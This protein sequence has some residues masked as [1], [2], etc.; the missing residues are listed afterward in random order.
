MVAVCA[1]VSGLADAVPQ[2]RALTNFVRELVN[3]PLHDGEYRFSLGQE[4]WVF[5]GF[6]APHFGAEAFLDGG[7]KPVV[8]FRGDE[9]PETMRR[10]KAG[11][12]VVRV[13]GAPAKGGGIR[14]HEVKTY[15][16]TAKTVSTFFTDVSEPGN[17]FG[18]EFYRRWLFPAFNT[19]VWTGGK[20]APGLPV[21]A[22]PSWREIVTQAPEGLNTFDA[23][24]VTGFGKGACDAGEDAKYICDQYV[25]RIATAD[26]Y[27]AIQG[28]A[29]PTLDCDEEMARWTARLVHHYCIE[30][31]SDSLAER[32]GYVCRPGHLSDGPES[33]SQRV[34]GL[35]PGKLYSLSY[36]TDSRGGDERDGVHVACAAADF[37]PE[38][39]IDWAAPAAAVT[40]H[41]LVFRAKAE[42]AELSLASGNGSRRPK[43]S[44]IA[45]RPYYVES[46]EELDTL[47][48]MS[49][50]Y[51]CGEKRKRILSHLAG[52]PCAVERQHSPWGGPKEILATHPDYV[53]FVP[54]Q[55]MFAARDPAKRGESYDDHFQV[56]DDPKRGL[57][58]AFW[59]QATKEAAPD[60]HI[61][62]SKSSD[63]GLTWTTPELVA[64]SETINHPRLVASWQQPMLAKSGRLYCLW[65]QQTTSR[66][67]HVGVIFG[68]FSDDAGDTWS[69]PKLVKFG[70]RPDLAGKDLEK[71]PAWCNWQR[72]LRL[73]KDGR[74]LVGS[75]IH[76]RPPDGKT[77]RTRV[78]FW[79]FENIDDNPNVEDI[80]ISC[81]A[82]DG[83]ALD[84]AMVEACG[85]R[86]FPDKP[87][88]R[89]TGA[90]EEA[91]IVKL[92][93]GRLFAL[94]RS[95]VGYPV[96]SVSADGGETWSRPKLL[97]DRDGGR[98]FLHPRSPCP[99]Y[100]WK[101]PEAGSGYYF[102]LV[103]DAFDFYG[104]RAYQPRGALYLLAGRFDPAAEQP[105]VFTRRKLFSPRPVGNSCYSSYTC[106][107]GQGVL[108]YNDRKYF[109]L[110]RII[111]EEF[112]K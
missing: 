97:R 104:E 89:S 67:P 107:N 96:W 100:D 18:Y 55:P 91:G 20:G 26:T 90:I 71:P 30:G 68:S 94:C 16:H 2:G 42:T 82:T 6:D 84:A 61:A 34:Q 37:V 76:G 69:P 32:F 56:L 23:A 54:N 24:L 44:R 92:P 45:V 15:L 78:E 59:T 46:E 50:K 43:I 103:H 27:C 13:A 29:M 111:G 35:V 106:A 33:V 60:Q 74:F 9:S 10:L 93:D 31:R 5:I 8:A 38:L 48:A 22:W 108:W 65:N 40:R 110:G 41:R 87:E 83:E 36:C 77:G 75:S 85:A 49:T 11:T 57:L 3:A 4:G 112:F 39:R 99:I 52:K 51:V 70:H 95:S 12:H 81:F 28:L 101:G 80:R 72:P 19:F 58:Y 102:A 73:G 105:I 53:A 47:R 86:L 64:G 21:G 98:P 14:I 17:G 7:E 62:F 88:N 66:G 1:C 79:R 109:L 25:R 63:G